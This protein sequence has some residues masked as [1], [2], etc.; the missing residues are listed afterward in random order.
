MSSSPLDLPILISQLPNVQQVL[1]PQHIPH[2]AQQVLFGQMV[3]ENQRKEEHNVQE[4]E[5]DEGLAA[6]GRDTG[7]NNKQAQQQAQRQAKPKHAAE[8][9]QTIGATS[10]SNASPWSGNI[11]NVKI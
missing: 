11:I 2:E 10:S 3:A 4:V 6:M 7:G 8:T 9:D 5:K 1:G